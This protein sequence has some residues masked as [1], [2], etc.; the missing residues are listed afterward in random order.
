VFPYTFGNNAI[1]KW[2]K[3]VNFMK[4]TNIISTEGNNT[5]IALQNYS[6]RSSKKIVVRN[7]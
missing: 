1:N 3:K 5:V 4:Y 7:E 2:G 6:E